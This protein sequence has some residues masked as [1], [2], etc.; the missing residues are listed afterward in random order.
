[1]DLIDKLQTEG[2][3][4][5]DEFCRL[6]WT[7]DAALR[8][9]LFMTA[10][11]IALA[12][13]GKQIYIRGLIEFTN[14]CWRDCFYCGLRCA[15]KKL[16]RYRMPNEVILDCCKTGYNMGFRTFVLQGGEDR[17]Y[18]DEVM[19]GIIRAI[20]H[21]YPD[22]AITLSLGERSLRSYKELF[23]AGADRYLLRHETA[24][25][26]HYSRLHPPSY[27]LAVRKDC[28]YDL[29]SI[30]YQVGS[31]FMVGSPYQL[32]EYLS[33]DFEFLRKLHPAMIGIGP[34]IPNKDTPFRHQKAGSLE[35]TLRCIAILRIMFPHANI[36]STT[37]LG[38]LHPEGRLHGILAGAN[39]LMPNLSPIEVQQHYT[40]YDRIGG[41]DGS[42]AENMELLG[43]QLAAHGYAMVVDRGAYVPELKKEL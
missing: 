4:T 42:L 30:G 14:Y 9:K 37:A 2:I 5:E 13:F 31:G 19:C 39:V 20:K 18:T 41:V 16:E 34:F 38:T 35:L 17:Y 26:L 25:S 27:S 29:Q 24:D 43:N 15:N 36:P 23:A 32:T 6:L 10:Q 12:S 11:Q 3:L 40:L 28:L 1:M 21:L 22:C 8:A 7:E 33:K